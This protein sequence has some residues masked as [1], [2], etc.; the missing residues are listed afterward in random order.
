MSGSKAF[1]YLRRPFMRNLLFLSAA[2]A[3]LISLSSCSGDEKPKAAGPRSGVWRMELDLGG[4][5]LPFLFDLSGDRSGWSVVI[6]NGEEKIAVKDVALRGDTMDIRMPLY[7]SEF[8]GIVR[9]D[10][11]ISGFWHNYL[12]G[13]DYKIPFVA[14]AGKRLRFNDGQP[15]KANIGGNWEVHFSGGTPDAYDALGIFQQEGA[16]ATGTFGTETGDYRFLEGLVSNDSLFLS[17]FDGSHAFLFKAEVRGDS[18]VGRY[19]SGIHW[20]EPWVAVR[21][22]NFALRDPDSLTTLREGYEMADFT[23][24]SIDGR[25][26]SPRDSAHAGK[27]LMVQIMGSWCPNCVDETLLLDEMYA[28]YRDR[29]LGVIA[30][31]FEKYDDHDRAIA[32]LKKFRDRLDVKYDLVYAG[33]AGKEEAAEKLPFLDHLMSYPTCIF[34]DRSGRVR[35]IRTGF[36]G[37]GTGNHYANYKRNLEHFLEQMLE[38]QGDA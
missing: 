14:R 6:H 17:C 30:I 36:Y 25:P 21:N 20:Q 5:I 11:T 9:N 37:P 4:H 12:K 29:G 19:W 15:A 34:I 35:R 27:V 26:I 22:E 31:A 28:R 18:M 13:P 33:R 7:D 3:L 2:T 24:P 16:I 23:F 32:Q 10:S 1:G 38:E 8:K